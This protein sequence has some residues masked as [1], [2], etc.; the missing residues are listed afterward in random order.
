MRNDK[1]IK[2]SIIAPL[3]L[4]LALT[5][6]CQPTVG[7]PIPTTTPEATATATLPP[8]T[9][10]ATVTPTEVPISSLPVDELVQKFIAGDVDD[11]SSLSMEQQMRFSQV[12]AEALNQKRGDNPV[13][14]KNQSYID[15]ITGKFSDINNGTSKQE[16]TIQMYLPAYENAEGYLMVQTQDGQWVQIEGSRN[17]R[18][19]VTNDPFDPNIKWP[20]AEIVDPQWVP[21]ANKDLIGL[22]IP[23]YI[24]G[25]NNYPTSMIPIVILGKELGELRIGGFGLTGSLKGLIIEKDAQGNPIAARVILLTGNMGLY[26]T[27]LTA[28]SSGGL[29]KTSAFWENLKANQLYYLMYQTDQKKCFDVTYPQL[30]GESTVDYTGLVSSNESHQ[31]ITNQISGQDLVWI[32]GELLMKTDD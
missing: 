11:I 2:H 22:T 25:R 3:F 14:Y 32:D 20:D 12:Y 7:I 9:P 18:Y 19:E 17:A 27:G 28:R 6:S 10:T 4:F 24:L 1:M 5:T 15:P 30:D 13:I 29:D 16:Q 26:E 21:E 8:A 31:V 23:Q